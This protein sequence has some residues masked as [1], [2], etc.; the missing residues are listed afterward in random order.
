MAISWGAIAMV[1]GAA[2]ARRNVA[3]PVANVVCEENQPVATDGAAPLPTVVEPLAT[4]DADDFPEITQAEAV[5]IYFADCMYEAAGGWL[6][7]RNVARG[8]A[9][10]ARRYGWPPVSDKRLSQLLRDNHGCTTRATHKRDANGRRLSIVIFPE[11]EA[12]PP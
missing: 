9:T 8:Y 2:P 7:F 5:A 11:C 12:P 4:D 10:G 1:F 3:P 6:T